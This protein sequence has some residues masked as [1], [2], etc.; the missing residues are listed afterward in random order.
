MGDPHYES[1]VDW[2]HKGRACLIQQ[3][4]DEIRAL[5]RLA[6]GSFCE[7]R[8]LEPFGFRSEDPLDEA[9]EWSVA[10]FATGELDP[11]RCTPTFR[12]FTEVR[13]WL[14]QKVG[15]RA[16][17]RIMRTRV[18]ARYAD[19]PE[20]QREPNDEPGRSYEVLNAMHRRLAR[21][22][23]HLAART[24]SDLVGYWL[25]GTRRLR[26]AWFGWTATI[27]IEIE[28]ASASKK[29]RSF[30][31]HD[32]LFRYQCLHQGLVPDADGSAPTVAVRES[33][34]RSCENQRPYRRPD[35]EVAPLL[36]AAHITGPRSVGKLRRAGLA[37]ILGRLFALFDGDAKG[38]QETLERVFLRT[39]LS[40]TTVHALDLERRDDLLT[41]VKSLPPA[42][43][44]V[45][46][47][48]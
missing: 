42:E 29:Q 41:R 17:I 28:N 38:E 27:E 22:L 33:M 30:H 45:P 23:Q 25:G 39:S 20:V 1:I 44:L 36:P 19:P 34:F 37:A 7:R 8:A 12:I 46:E 14:A 5:L 48:P 4:G 16:Y 40:A 24:C 3:R 15:T 43:S 9:V 47:E 26:S 2:S 31:V 18:E 11:E 32:A 35:E 10:R 6:F 13:F 21:T